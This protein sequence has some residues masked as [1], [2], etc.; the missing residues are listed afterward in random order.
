MTET[1]KERI[2]REALEEIKFNGDVALDEQKSNSEPTYQSSA[3]KQFDIA[4]LALTKGDKIP[5]SSVSTDKLSVEKLQLNTAVEA[6]TESKALLRD[7][8]RE[9]DGLNKPKETLYNIIQ[10]ALE[11]WRREKMSKIIKC[12][13]CHEM[14]GLKYNV[15][16]VYQSRCQNMECRE[17]VTVTAPSQKAAEELLS[18]FEKG[19]AQPRTNGNQR[20][21]TY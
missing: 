17:T 13:I 1:A 8:N 12:P 16:R 10:Q 20:K 21:I 5:A 19:T 11:G 7:M 3:G 4:R 18:K 14:S 9:C 15:N 6:L 2:Y